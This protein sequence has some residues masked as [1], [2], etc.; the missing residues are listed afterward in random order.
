MLAKFFKIA[1]HGLFKTLSE[2]GEADQFYSDDQLELL[3]QSVHQLTTQFVEEV[4]PDGQEPSNSAL[5]EMIEQ[6]AD[7]IFNAPE[8]RRRLF[9]VS[10]IEQKHILDQ[11]AL[12]DKFKKIEKAK[13]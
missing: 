8:I 12:N 11:E 13:D 5:A 10:T 1:S 2:I 9:E 4:C 6:K 7:W 3:A